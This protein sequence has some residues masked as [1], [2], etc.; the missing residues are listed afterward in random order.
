MW[1]L[2][3]ASLAEKLCSSFAEGK[4]MLLCN[5]I[6]TT[7]RGRSNNSQQSVQLLQP[8]ANPQRERGQSGHTCLV[9]FRKPVCAVGHGW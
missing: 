9:T 8:L 6:R 4:F 3:K 7:K 5:E 2:Y 1:L